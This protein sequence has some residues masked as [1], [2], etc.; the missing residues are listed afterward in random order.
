MILVL[1]IGAAF[2]LVAMYYFLTKQLRLIVRPVNSSQAQT[3]DMETFS[4]KKDSN[5]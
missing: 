5:T 1:C 3:E 4:L 2:M